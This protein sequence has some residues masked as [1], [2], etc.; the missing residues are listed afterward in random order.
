MKFVTL[1]LET[2]LILARNF[3]IINNQLFQKKER[4]ASE[5]I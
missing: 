4:N 1:N 3:S 2:S 5:K